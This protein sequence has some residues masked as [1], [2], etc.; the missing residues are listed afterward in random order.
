MQKILYKETQSNPILI[1]V[2]AVVSIF[3][4]GLFLMQVITHRPIG[5]HPAPTWLLFVFF[6]GSVI[7]TVFFG[8]QKLKLLITEDE[9]HISFGLLTRETTLRISDIKSIYIR[10]YDGLKEFLGWGIKYSSDTSCFTVSGDDGIQ[11]DMN[12]GRRFLVGTHNVASV[13]PVIDNLQSRVNAR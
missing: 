3:I 13:K 9:I 2:F 4:G 8:R 12:D 10:K 1:V 6:I 7:A 11:I 5:N